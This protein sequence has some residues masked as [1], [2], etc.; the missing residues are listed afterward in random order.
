MCSGNTFSL[1]KIRC[2]IHQNLGGTDSVQTLWLV[3]P[4]ECLT[5]GDDDNKPGRDLELLPIPSLTAGN[6]T[7]KQLHTL[8]KESKSEGW[9]F[10]SSDFFKYIYLIFKRG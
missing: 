4:S 8:Q 2:Q 3:V 7:E 10:S 6:L 1:D 9:Q 5:Y